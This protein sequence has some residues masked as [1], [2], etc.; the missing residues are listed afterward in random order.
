MS[1]VQVPE[2]F[3]R[4]GEWLSGDSFR[5]YIHQHL[6]LEIV[7]GSMSHVLLK[8]LGGELN[9]VSLEGKEGGVVGDNWCHLS[10]AGK[11]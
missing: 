10:Y 9:H 5:P 8:H 11:L 6:P 2:P 1:S 4:Q 3:L 7:S